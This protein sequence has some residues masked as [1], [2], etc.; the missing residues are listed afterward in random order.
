MFFLGLF[1]GAIIGVM[2]LAIVSASKNCDYETTC[3]NCK[4]CICNS[5]F[6]CECNINGVTMYEPE[7]IYCG[8]FE[9][10]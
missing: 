8:K 3:I 6:E 1:L 2:A 10:R 5:D 7:T 4:H 9:V